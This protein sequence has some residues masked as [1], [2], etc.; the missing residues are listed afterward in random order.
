[1]PITVI[2]DLGGGERG[3]PS[4]PSWLG[5]LAFRPI[6][7]VCTDWRLYGSGQVL[8]HI[9]ICTRVGGICSQQE[10]QEQ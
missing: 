2:K 7:I 10:Q 8:V 5:F 1:M 3:G 4:F 9:M 6:W